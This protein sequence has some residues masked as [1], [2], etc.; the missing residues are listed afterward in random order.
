MYEYLCQHPLVVRGKRRETHYFDW[1]YN[2]KIADSDAAAHLKFYMN[3]FHAEALDKHIS[4]IT[5]ES[6]PSYLLHTC[7]VW[8]LFYVFCLFLHVFVD[9]FLLYRGYTETFRVFTNTFL[10]CHKSLNHTHITPFKRTTS[11]RCCHSPY[12]A[13]LSL[14]QTDCHAAEPH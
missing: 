6:T 10:P 11:Q 3:F 13:H 5:G 7:V 8:L 12:A 4:L 1:R 2:H 9:S 14:G